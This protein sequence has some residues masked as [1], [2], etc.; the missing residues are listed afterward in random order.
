MR[1]RQSPQGLKPASLL[2]LD[3]TAEAVPFPIRYIPACHLA[4]LLSSRW[5][6][7]LRKHF[8]DAFDLGADGAEFFFDVFVA[9]ID[10]VDAVDDGFAIGDEGGEDE[11][12]RGA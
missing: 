2:D 11:G 6:R 3:G 1:C 4:H 8:T 7:F 5:S 10:V 9:A 12:C